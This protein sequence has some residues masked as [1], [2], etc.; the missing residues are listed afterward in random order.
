MHDPRLLR[1]RAAHRTWRAGA[2]RKW[3]GLQCRRRQL[4]WRSHVGHRRCGRRIPVDWRRQRR[5]GRRQGG[6]D[7]RIPRWRGF[8]QRRLWRGRR[9]FRHS[10]RGGSRLLRGGG[11]GH[12]GLRWRHGSIQCKFDHDGFKRRR[13]ATHRKFHADDNRT[14]QRQR[15][16]KRKR[17]AALAARSSRTCPPCRLCAHRRSRPMLWAS[18]PRQQRMCVIQHWWSL[19]RLQRPIGYSTMTF[20]FFNDI[21]AEQA[22]SFL[23]RRP[24]WGVDGVD[25]NYGA[26][27]TI[28]VTGANP[29]A[30]RSLLRPGG[31]GLEA[32]GC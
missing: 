24:D 12:H 7:R 32:A 8:G 19:P 25:R 5:F 4:W 2:W 17:H 14:L 20:A 16:D 22:F 11:L 21:A 30:I 29:R 15:K 9:C 31:R 3:R 1:R 13:R 10:S 18:R 6:G 27:A 28:K 23:P 26:N